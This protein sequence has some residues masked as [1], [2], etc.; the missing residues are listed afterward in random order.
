MHHNYPCSLT[1][2]AISRR[3]CGLLISAASLFFTRQTMG[4]GVQPPSDVITP[5]FISFSSE[6]W[7]VRAVINGTAL[8]IPRNFV[9]VA[10][11]QKRSPDTPATDR[12]VG[13]LRLVTFFPGFGGV[14]PEKI[15]TVK[16]SSSTR[17]PDLVRINIL[18]NDDVW[19]REIREGRQIQAREATTPSDY[20]LLIR[21]EA[22]ADV[23]RPVTSSD[24]EPILILRIR[25]S[26]DSG[27]CKVDLFRWPQLYV[28]YEYNGSL[29]GHWKAID[30]GV[31]AT[32]NSFLGSR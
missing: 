6:T 23:F 24:G 19:S 7:I 14:T 26:G 5:E 21:Q 3:Q 1:I 29:I 4:Q 15:K 30:D 28:E 9:E 13:W 25:T 22:Q 20:G 8:N 17:Y 31:T 16:A 27:F 32:I 10:M 18:P 2:S 12:K 11:V